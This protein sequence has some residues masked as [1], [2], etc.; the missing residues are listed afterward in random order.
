MYLAA[1]LVVLGE[2]SPFGSLPLLLYVGARTVFL[3]ISA[4]PLPGYWSSPSSRR[5]IFSRCRSLSE[6]VSRAS[7]YCSIDLS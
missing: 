6:S 4:N 5:A 2:T 3:L 1:L 7:A